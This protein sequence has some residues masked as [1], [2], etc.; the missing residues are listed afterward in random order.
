MIG[1]TLQI[2][3]DMSGTADMPKYSKKFGVNLHACLREVNEQLLADYKNGRVELSERKSDM[4]NLL[5]I[6]GF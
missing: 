2:L 6:R 5:I 3:H 1:L 4:C